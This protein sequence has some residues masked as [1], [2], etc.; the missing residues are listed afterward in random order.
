MPASEAAW[1]S[2]EALSSQFSLAR[3][4]RGMQET[5]TG[6]VT[7]LPAAALSLTALGVRAFPRI[8]PFSPPRIRK[9]TVI[10]SHR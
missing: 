8:T 1:C 6:G 9:F 3:G 5:A 4:Q 2:K 10:P 7:M